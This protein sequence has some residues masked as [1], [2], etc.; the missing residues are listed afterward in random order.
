MTDAVVVDDVRKRFR[1][2]H[3]RNATIKAMVMRGMKRVIYEEFWALDGVSFDITEGATFG[4]I[5]KNGSGKSTL[6]KCMAKIYQPDAGSITINGKM[7]ALLELGAGFHPELSG[8]EN[9]YLN[10]SILGLSRR[11][12]DL[13]FD[14]IV[15]FAG[16]ERFID[17]P[18]KNY[19]SGM[20]VRLGFSVAINVEPE[21]L[22]VDEVLAVGDETFQRRCME[23]FA[24]FRSEGR[25]IVV[26]T[27]SL[28]TVRN[29]CDQ[30]A[31]LDHGVLR[32][33]G[34]AGSVVGDYLAELDGQ[35]AGADATRYDSERAS[36]VDA[37]MSLDGIGP[38]TTAL[39]GAPLELLVHLDRR[40]PEPIRLELTIHR[41]DGI[42]ISGARMTLPPGNPGPTTARYRVE[43][44]DLRA[45][46]YILSVEV[47]DD[48]STETLA[49]LA[50][51]VAFS[52]AGEPDGSG[53]VSL[54]GTWA[55][56]GS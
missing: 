11:D 50:D 12:I 20:F 51:A 28:D 39:S 1:L 22:L 14:D 43:S 42:H 8:R 56:P 17:H 15:E 10:G 46:D 2:V 3:E 48:H 23:R 18:V 38:T 19:S 54:G 53:L 9:V 34:A 13:R 32:S 30:A 52:V 29:I 4:L 45:G 55:D 5:G 33:V 25:T 31:W 24:Q 7:S 49:K 16:L 40:S 27:H 35:R 37:E 26:V 21:V 44:L 6:L 36:I 41:A 47:T